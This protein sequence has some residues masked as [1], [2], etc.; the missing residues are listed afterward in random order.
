MERALN[1]K[2]AKLQK[3]NTSSEEIPKLEVSGRRSP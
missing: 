1:A 3:L 2:A